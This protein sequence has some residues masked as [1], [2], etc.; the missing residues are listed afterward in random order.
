MA[1]QDDVFGMSDSAVD[2]KTPPSEKVVGWF[3]GRV[4]TSKPSD[5]HHRLG[6]GPGEASPGPH[7][8]DG[9]DSLPLFDATEIVLTDISNTATGTQIATAVNAINAA[10]RRLGA[11][12]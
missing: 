11:G 2:G 7:R 5:V 9:K 4:S 10:L 8:H 1:N 6:F 3:H 12:G